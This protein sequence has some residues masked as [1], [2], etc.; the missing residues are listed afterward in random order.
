MG[1]CAFGQTDSTN[2]TLTLA[3]AKRIAFERNWDLLAA[4]E[5]VNVALAQRVVSKEFPNPTLSAS[6]QKINVDN[7]P[8]STASGNGFWDRNYDTIVAV[9]QLFEI[10][11]KRK[12]RQLGA[13]ATFEQARAQLWDARRTLDAAITKA[14]IATLLADQNAKALA[15]SANPCARK[16]KS[17]AYVSK[18]ATSP[19]PTNHKSKSLPTVSH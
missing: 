17:R 13:T 1:F 19:S 10:G 14:Y 11:G 15:T 2:R 18:A 9:N 12:A 6:V 8:A 7:H 3:H 16:K 4:K 5:G